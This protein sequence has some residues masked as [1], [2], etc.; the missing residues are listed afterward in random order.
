MPDSDT[1][2]LQF[3]QARLSEG[4]AMKHSRSFERV[5]NG[6]SLLLSIVFLILLWLPTLDS[7]FNLDRVPWVNEKRP[8]AK[9]PQVILSV[10]GVRA[11]PAG[12]EAYFSDHFGFRRRL[13]RCEQKWKHELFREATHPDVMIGRNGWL[14]YTGEQMI[15]HF[16]GAKL[17]TPEDLKNWQALLEK[18]RDWLANRGI[19]YLF[20]IPP[21]KHSVYPEYLPDW[22][23]KVGPQTKLDQF[24]AHMKT[25]SS[26]EVL[27]LRPALLE[28]KKTGRTYLYTDTHWNAYGAFFAYRAFMR[29]L[30]RQLPELGEPLPYEA[31]D[32]ASSEEKGGDLAVLLGQTMAEKDVVNLN[33]RPPLRLQETKEDISIFAKQWPKYTQPVYTENPSRRYSL[34][35]FRDSFSN[36]WTAFVG[37][38]FKRSVYI[39]QYNWD[40]KVIEREKPNVVVDEMLERMFNLQDPKKLMKDDQLS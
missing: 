21:D 3:L 2:S 27:D 8:P 39:W 5:N 36:S 12:L 19:K 26:V 30:A 24:I 18:R 14:F 38:N 7:F 28:A 9:F 22:L 33:P 16:R 40:G 10:N 23:T 35:S 11:L 20:V 4:V 6:M 31:F 29:A 15:E 25:H 32:T 13:I 37:F 17:F 34:L 1:A